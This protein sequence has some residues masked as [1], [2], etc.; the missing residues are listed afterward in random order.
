MTTGLVRSV[1]PPGDLLAAAHALVA[2][3]AANTAP[4]AVALSRQM[5]W[6]M[7]GADHPMMAHR[8]DSRFVASQGSSGD[9]AEGVTAFL[10]KR[11]PDFPN[12]VSTGLP[13]FYPP[14]T[15]PPYE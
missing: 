14:W 8:I 2:E 5:L 15:E 7:L 4:V 3:I 6:R 9:V 1:H 10:E 11:P 13:S 12:Q